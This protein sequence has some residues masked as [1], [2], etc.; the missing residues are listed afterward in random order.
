MLELFEVFDAPTEVLQLEKQQIKQL[1]AAGTVHGPEKQR[2]V[3][4]LDSSLCVLRD[5]M[6]RKC[7]LLV[8]WLARKASNKVNNVRTKVKAL[9]GKKSQRCTQ[10]STHLLQWPTQNTRNRKKCIPVT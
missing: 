1:L 10:G 9:F 5:R 2:C 6:S 8:E 4:Y 7:G 3:T